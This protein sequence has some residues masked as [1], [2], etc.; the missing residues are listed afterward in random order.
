MPSV[1]VH[2]GVVQWHKLRIATAH[3]DAAMQVGPEG[4]GG[5]LL[6]GEKIIALVSDLPCAASQRDHPPARPSAQRTQ[7][8]KKPIRLS[9]ILDKLF[10]NAFR[11]GASTVR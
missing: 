4:Q 2:C 6:L 1:S 11:L 3:A 8:M 9:V 10:L 7:S 5:P